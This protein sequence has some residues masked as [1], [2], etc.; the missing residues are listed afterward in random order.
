MRIVWNIGACVL[1]GL[2]YELA[3]GYSYILSGELGMA[4]QAIPNS[5]ELPG[6]VWFSTWA[7][8]VFVP[9]AAIAAWILCR[10]AQR[11]LIL[12]TIL[13]L[14]P[15]L[16]IRLFGYTVWSQLDFGPGYILSNYA[17]LISAIFI[18]L[19]FVWIWHDRFAGS[20]A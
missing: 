16:V 12:G 8:L 14:I 13:F 1:I 5:L 2:S 20:A 19:I 18:P 10:V 11:S 9:I 3:L 7:I 15:V 17:E 6:I 4:T